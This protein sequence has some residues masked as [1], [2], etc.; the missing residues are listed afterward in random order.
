[1]GQ[2][3]PSGALVLSLWAAAARAAE[4]QAGWHSIESWQ[5]PQG[6]PQN[7][8]LAVIQTRDGYIWV[9]TKGGVARFDGVRFKTFDDRSK[10]ELLD[11]EV[12]ALLEGDDG[13]LW[14]GTYGGG[15]SRYKDGRF[16]TYTTRD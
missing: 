11:S 7:T 2:L 8:V 12:Q 4:P 9:G 13:S 6:L 5:Q 16:T 15:L 3:R 1:M 14:V 10:T